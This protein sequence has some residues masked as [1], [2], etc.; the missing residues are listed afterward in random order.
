MTGRT[1]SHYEILDKL[2]EGGMGEVFKARDLR[3]NRLAAIKVLPA[4]KMA[5]QNRK[6]RFV[7]EAQT[8][9]SLNHPN[10][11]TI[12]G[13][14]RDGDIDFI[15]MEYL[16]G[17]T[18][19]QLIA[20]R[21]LRLVDSLKYSIQIAEALAAAHAA[22]VVHSDLKPANV[23]VADNGLVKVL[24]FGLAKLGEPAEPVREGAT[25]TLHVHAPLTEQGTVLGTVSYMS[26]EQAEGK[27]VDARS[28]IFSFGSILFEMVTGRRA[29]QGDSKMSTIS[30]ILRD[31]PKLGSSSGS[32]AVPRDLE[33]IIVRC[34]RKE[35][36]RRFQH[37]DD[38]K[39]ALEELKEESDSGSLVAS[40]VPNRKSRLLPWV[41]A[42]LGTVL[43]CVLAGV[44]VWRSRPAVSNGLKL[45]QLTQD[46]GFTGY[47]AISPDGKLIAYASDR[48]G[49][50]GLDIWVQQLSRGSQ[51]IRLTKDPADEF[52]P[53]FS[54]DGGQI[55]FSSQRDGGGIYVIPS[56]GGEERLIMRGELTN[57][58]FSPDGQSIAVFTFGSFTP[59]TFLIP[60][61]G[62]APHQVGANFYAARFVTWS[63]DGKKILISGSRDV[64][65]DLDW[66]VIPLDGG[67]PVQTAAMGALRRGTLDAGR[68]G[69]WLDDYVLYSDGNLWR[70]KLPVSSGKV[71]G[72][73][74]RLTTSSTGEAWPRAIPADSRKA[75]SWK[76][77]FA[78]GQ[79]ST[80]LWS[81]AIDPSGGKLSGEP[82]KLIA[83]AVDRESPSLSADGAK[84]AYVAHQ[85]DSYSLRVREIATGAEKT[86]IQQTT[87]FRARISPD[88]SRVAY[89]PTDNSEKEN[90]I[91]LVSTSGGESR[92]LCETCGLIYE[93]T[94]DGKRIL[95]RSGNPMKF[96]SIDAMNEQQQVVLA[97]AN[98]HV[99]GVMYSPDQHW[100]ALHYAPNL[101]SPRPIY[102]APIR[103]G[104]VAE[105]SEWIP[106]MDR[107]GRQ[108]RPW[109]SQ[110]GNVLYFLST[111]G[112]KHE[113]WAQRLQ[114]LT[115][116]PAGEP[117][118]LYSPPVER[119]SINT[120]T[121]FGPGI[122][123]NHL[124]FPM[125]EQTSNIWIAE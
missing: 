61:A 43:A 4:D 45:R 33:K 98:H 87:S 78:S 26:P 6:A 30:A 109:W 2:G 105:K 66:W 42:A 108:T 94:P 72:E 12:Y 91:H 20:R 18:L 5:D 51:P 67:P 101:G 17:R 71:T 21:G 40:E 106:V 120:G 38:V 35:V 13:I 96:S 92:K 1:I 68:I 104:H 122:G 119:Y 8:A 36:S 31:E 73:P 82:R 102:I 84:L 95:F 57:P 23:M 107:P 86:L 121:W 117:I 3:L 100:I 123:P 75:S 116:H 64:S 16:Q 124:I 49:N 7:Q 97:D 11:V 22:G 47:P 27:P 52:F 69:E 44:L 34:L 83:D 90:T 14:D 114:P 81:V 93:W 53:S 29:F 80:N 48:A 39:V 125:R 113:I 58:R 76:I 103:D 41:L 85:L 32:N 111:S 63:P 25:R 74:E 9:S 37:M 62:G 55:V 112:G 77:V 15:A 65:S 50:A 118:L 24:D 110:D 28:D 10:I 46:S 88:G 99:H 70:I 79:G 60:S 54:P 56:L 19:D 59:K 115:K 89:N